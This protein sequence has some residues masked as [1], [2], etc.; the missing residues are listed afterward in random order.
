MGGQ[1][2]VAERN[3]ER[4]LD[5]IGPAVHPD[6]SGMRDRG[7]GPVIL[8]MVQ[9]GSLPAGGVWGGGAPPASNFRVFFLF[10]HFLSDSKIKQVDP[11]C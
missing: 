4:A 6:P 8:G 3:R 7:V 1:L 11:G 9:G 10:L 2:H 5:V